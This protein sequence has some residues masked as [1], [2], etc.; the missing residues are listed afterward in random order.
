MIDSISIERS[1]EI[2]TLLAVKP[3]Q[4]LLFDF[5]LI[6]TSN[7]DHFKFPAPLLK[8]SMDGLTN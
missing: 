3:N 6:L 8:R 2:H 1:Y 4:A 7:I 5:R